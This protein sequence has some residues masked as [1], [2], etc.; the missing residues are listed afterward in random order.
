M[1]RGVVLLAACSLSTSFTNPSNY[2][3]CRRSRS[4]KRRFANGPVKVPS[5]IASLGNSHRHSLGSV[6]V[7]SHGV[8]YSEA[9]LSQMIVLK[10]AME[11]TQPLWGPPD[12]YL[13]AG[14]SIAPSAKSLADLGIEKSTEGWPE[15]AQ[16]AVKDGVSVIDKAAIHAESLLPG[17]ASVHGILP[18]HD[19]GVPPETPATFAAQV[20]WAAGFLNV[21]DKLPEAAFAYA[22]IEFFILRPGIDM[23]KEDVE[24]DPGRAFADTLAVAGVRLG[25][26]CIV[27]AVTTTI[28]G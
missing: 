10:P 6:Y 22:L 14:R 15:L 1:R 21:V 27:A 7:N 8:R 24:E 18:S 11:H 2:N 23:Y 16:M 19:P 25:M 5:P 4:V 20:E 26:F 3:P 9:V 17:F 13:S 28:F 12:P